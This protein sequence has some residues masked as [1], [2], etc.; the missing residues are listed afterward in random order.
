MPRH[1]DFRTLSTQRWRR[2]APTR[3]SPRIPHPR[4]RYPYRRRYGLGQYADPLSL[5]SYEYRM[6]EKLY[7]VDKKNS[8]KHGL[9]YPEKIS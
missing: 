1:A 3:I 2:S 4:S 7:M 5:P 8:R 9:S 6:R